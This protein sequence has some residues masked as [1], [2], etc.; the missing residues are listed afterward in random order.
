MAPPAYWG[1]AVSLFA[2]QPEKR[3]RIKSRERR[4]ENRRSYRKA[5]DLEMSLPYVAFLVVMVVMIVMSCVKYLDMNSQASE[6]NN[7][8]A[9][10]QTKLDTLRTKNDAIE[11]EI[12]GYV[13]V[14]YIISTAMNELGMVVAGKEQVTFYENTPSE[15]MNQLNDVPEE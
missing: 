3:E 11:Y 6:Y 1:A 9:T 4:R 10:L 8:K 12:D 13:D 7:K 5:D 14:E 2:P 15:Y